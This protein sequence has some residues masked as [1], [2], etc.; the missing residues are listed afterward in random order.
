MQLWPAVVGGAS[1]VAATGAWAAMHPGARIFGPTLTTVPAPSTIAL[2]FD[3]GPNPAA[4]P[5]LLD[6]LERHGAA[7][8]FFMIGQWAAACPSIVRLVAAR[9]HTIGNHT[10]TH[11]NLV[12]MT[13]PRIVAELSQCQDAIGSIAHRRPTLVRP[14]YGFR[15][16]QFHRAAVR[17][18]LER[19]VMWR[20]TGRD[21][22]PRGQRSLH[23][24]LST[25][26]GGD[27]VLLH[28]GSHTALGADR[29]PTLRALEYWLPRWRDAGLRCTALDG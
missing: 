21:W 20:V 29:S 24:R 22:T 3:D 19:V 4:T 6:L 16:P 10:H 5:A 25:V 23:A 14:P 9:G 27:I 15:G 11:P 18:G 12:W 2:T 8:T 26:R 7:A 13:P 17:S 28:D 1:V